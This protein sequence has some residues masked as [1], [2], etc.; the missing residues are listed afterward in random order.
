MAAPGWEWA[1]RLVLC[2]L[3]LV[4]SVYALHVE[5]SRERDPGY[6]AMCDLSPSVSCSKVFTSSH[7]QVQKEKHFLLSGLDSVNGASP[8]PVHLLGC[9][10]SSLIPIHSRSGFSITK[11][12]KQV[13]MCL[14]QGLS[15]FIALRPPSDNKNYYTTP[16][17]GTEA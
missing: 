10:S 2:A 9:V 12:V 14:M 11:N 17:G 15:N 7:R 16:G 13:M 5:S 1:L 3:G 8:P 6:R 4:L